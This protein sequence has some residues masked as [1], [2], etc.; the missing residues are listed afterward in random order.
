MEDHTGSVLGYFW[1]KLTAGPAL[2]LRKLANW[3]A[4]KRCWVQLE[5]FRSIYFRWTSLVKSLLRK[6]K[7]DG[8]DDAKQPQSNP[9]QDDAEYVKDC[10]V[11][12]NICW[13]VTI[14]DSSK[15]WV[16]FQIFQICQ[17]EWTNRT[18]RKKDRIGY[19]R[20]RS[21]EFQ[22]SWPERTR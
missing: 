12:T 6:A 9:S 20:A 10:A 22:S 11:R 16:Q 3:T 4:C 19:V 14:C 17:I 15:W 13:T 2:G 18:V 5:A 1:D 7:F 21:D 8:R